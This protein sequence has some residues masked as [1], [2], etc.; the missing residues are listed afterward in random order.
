MTNNARYEIPKISASGSETDV[1]VKAKE[2]LVDCFVFSD[3][4]L[5]LYEKTPGG[6]LEWIG[7]M[8]LH[9]AFLK[10]PFHGNRVLNGVY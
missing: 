2:K 8:T 10:L 9:D 4:F 1:P 7:H 5:T 3:M 6:E